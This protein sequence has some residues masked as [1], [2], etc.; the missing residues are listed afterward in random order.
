MV[1]LPGVFLSLWCDNYDDAEGSPA[2]RR[3][4]RATHLYSVG[5]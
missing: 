5:R 1:I 3:E 4:R 2:I